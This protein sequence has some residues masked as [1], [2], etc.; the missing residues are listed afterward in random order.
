MLNRRGFLTATLG[1]LAG[2]GKSPEPAAAP[3]GL[4][5]AP[6]GHLTEDDVR[7]FLEIVRRLPGQKPPAFQPASELDL[8]ADTRAQGMVERWQGEF[9]SSYSP[10]TQAR[11]WKRDTSVR[12]ALNDCG[13]AP[14]EFASLLVRL[15]AAVVRESV[16]PGVDLTML[17]EQADRTIASL[18]SQFDGLSRDPRLS[19]TVRNARAELLSMMLKESVAYRE[20]LRLLESISPESVA[21]VS[22]HRDVLRPLM[23]ATETVLAFEKKLQSQSHVIRVSHEAPARAPAPGRGQKQP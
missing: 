19:P 13:I 18:C 11:F 2:C 4:S 17:G 22:R 20:F 6:D 5:R 23:P 10:Q 9:R 8:T 21:A 15:S 14:E 3:L 7:T 16:D 1:V 12:G